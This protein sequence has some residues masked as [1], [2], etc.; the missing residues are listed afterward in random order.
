MDYQWAQI[1]CLTVLFILFTPFLGHYMATIF[2][3]RRSFLHPLLHGLEN[4]CYRAAGVNSKEEMTPFIYAKSWLIFNLLGFCAVYLLL[5]FQYYLPLNPQH[6]PAPSWHSIYNTAMSFATNTNWQSYAGETTLSYLSQMLGLAVQNFLSAAAGMAALLALIRGI[7]RKCSDTIG[8]FWTDLVRALVYLFLPLSIL[9]AIALAYEGVVQTFSPYVEVFTLENSKQ[10][11]PLGPAASQ[12]AIKQLG[13]NGGGFFNANSA[14]PFE[15]PTSFS[16]FLEC[17]AILLI[18]AATVYMY[19][20]MIGSKKHAWLIFS[21]MLF[22]WV[23]G[24]VLSFYSEYLHNP[25]LNAYPPLEGKETR[26]GITNSLLWSV[27]TTAVANGSVNAMMSS[28]SPIAGGIALFNILVGELIFGGIGVGLSSMIM[29]ILLTVFLSGLMVGRTPEYLGKKIEK[30]EMQWVVL[31]I[32]I[33]VSM[34]LI[35]AGI[36]FVIPSALSSLSH[37]GPHGLSEMLYAFASAA[38]TNGSAFA[39]L[40]ADTPYFNVIL[41]TIMLIARVTIVVASIAIGGLLAKKKVSPPS[42]GTFSTNTFLFFILLISVIL[43]EGAL[44]YFPALAL[45]PFTEQ[46]L[47]LQGRFF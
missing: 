40:N 29:F 42:L 4:L 19:G 11:I 20:L 2:S 10:M 22:F 32:L 30:K 41:G 28:L 17:L 39:G 21:A 43:I 33:P 38:G 1:L 18:P 9:L 7:V 13:T 47:M 35:G 27:S 15:N 45:G 44:T 3:G 6:L 14:H 37:K 46:V 31:T 12:I 26:L 24:L 8:N 34:V 25:L 5:L 36:S 23:G 16:N